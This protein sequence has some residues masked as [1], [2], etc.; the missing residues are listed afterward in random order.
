MVSTQQNVH[1]VPYKSFPSMIR[2]GEKTKKKE[3]K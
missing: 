2:K 1:R 3:F